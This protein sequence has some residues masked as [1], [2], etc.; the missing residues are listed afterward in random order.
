M[1]KK[2]GFT[3]SRRLGN[4]HGISQMATDVPDSARYWLSLNFLLPE[5]SSWANATKRRLIPSS[6]KRI[7]TL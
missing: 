7:E 5:A 3:A 6:L 2:V 4:K 1:K